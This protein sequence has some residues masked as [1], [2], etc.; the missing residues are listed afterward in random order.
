M[1][2]IWRPICLTEKETKTKPLKSP[3]KDNVEIEKSSTLTR[4]MDQYFALDMVI[5]VS[6]IGT[7]PCMKEI[8]YVSF[9]LLLCL[10][11]YIFPVRVEDSHWITDVMHI[12]KRV[13]VLDSLYTLVTTMKVDE[14]LLCSLL[15]TTWK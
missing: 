14:T 8:I 6:T 15:I 5:K 9:K 13:S 12:P 7:M 2:R 10:C 4:S 11:R 1:S 3:F